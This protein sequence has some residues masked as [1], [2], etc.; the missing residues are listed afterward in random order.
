MLKNVLRSWILSLQD[1]G[2]AKTFIA[3]H[4]T[5]PECASMPQTDFCM[6]GFSTYHPAT[7]QPHS[8]LNTK[9]FW[10]AWSKIHHSMEQVMAWFQSAATTL[11]TIGE[12]SAW[13]FRHHIARPCHLHIRNTS[14]LAILQLGSVARS[15]MR[16]GSLH[17]DIVAMQPQLGQHPVDSQR[18]SQSLDSTDDGK[19]LYLQTA[20]CKNS[21]HERVQKENR[22]LLV[23]TVWAL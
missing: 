15:L 16:L 17:S 8:L 7:H 1:I 5:W 2:M 11:F 3:T 18:R 14:N 13:Q 21:N 22:T 20:C 6:V 23:C 9:P 4:E 19:S 10:T 12:A